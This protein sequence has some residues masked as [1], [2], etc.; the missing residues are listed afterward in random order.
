[1]SDTSFPEA[2]PTTSGWLAV[3]A[4]AFCGAVFCATEFLP[5]GILRYISSNLAVSEGTAGLM[6]TIPGILA[7]IAGPLTTLGIGKIDRKKILIFLTVLLIIANLLAMFT[8]SFMMLLVGR[9]L[10]G[11]GLGGFW[12]VGMGVAS[13]LVQPQSVGR[14]TSVIFTAISVGLLIGGPVGSFI[15]DAFGWRYAFG[16]ATV[17]SMLALIFLVLTLPSLQVSQRVKITDFTQILR[18]RNGVVGILAMFLI[19]VAHF[20]TY[21]YITAFLSAKTGFSG[22]AISLTLLAYTLLGLLGNFVGGAAS[23]KNVKSTLV[24][25]IV[26]LL[27][28]VALLPSLSGNIGLT[29][30]LIVLWGFAYGIIPI[31]LQIWMIKAAPNA[32]E[33]GTAL[34]VAN[35]QT[36]I[37]CGSFLGGVII[38]HAGLITMMYSGATVAALS[39]LTI[40]IMA[41]SWNKMKK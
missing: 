27:F 13:R 10:F 21:T 41:K 8:T 11:I 31:A 37:A 12:A 17:L 1:M 3:F 34:Y 16:L 33:G 22:S 29:T 28:A 5:I 15:G 39:L 23:D 40:V 2:K 32:H 20:G 38:D 14:A 30:I 36:S 35:F 7:A 19:I 4:I 6:M 18:S 25:G 9:L 24:A 26:L